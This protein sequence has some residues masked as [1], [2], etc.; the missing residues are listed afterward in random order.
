[1][2]GHPNLP[3][4]VTQ[5]TI[6]RAYYGPKCRRCGRRGD[7]RRG[8]PNGDQGHPDPEAKYC[9]VCNESTGA[10]TERAENLPYCS[11]HGPQDF[12]VLVDEQT[13]DTDSEPSNHD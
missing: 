7:H 6:D 5:E 3:P 11:D 12:L 4:G 10:G 2:V 1:M 9:V 13:D 8:C